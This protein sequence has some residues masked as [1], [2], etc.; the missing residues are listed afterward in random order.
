MW[1]SAGTE[2]LNAGDPAGAL[3]LFQRATAASERYA[4][5][6]YQMGRALQAL[7]QHDA[8]R[9]AFARASELNPSLVPPGTES[10]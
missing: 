9:R 10:P 8:A 6:F 4:P 2:K 7:G 5:A 3:A 1:T